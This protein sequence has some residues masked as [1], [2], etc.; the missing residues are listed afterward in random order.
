VLG[1]EEGLDSVISHKPAIPN[2]NRIKEVGLETYLEEQ[3]E[4]R[5]LVEHLLANYNEGRSMSFYCVACTLTPPDLIRQA[6]GEMERVLASGQVDASDLK[7]KARA[8]RS[9]IQG[10]ASQAGIDLKLRKKRS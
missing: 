7:A 9:S 1:V 6:I 2:L 3:R 10:L 5:L 4:R 8:M